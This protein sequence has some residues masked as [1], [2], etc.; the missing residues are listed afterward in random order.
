MFKCLIDGG[1]SDWIS[2]IYCLVSCG[3]GIKNWKRF[4]NF[5]LLLFGGY[6]C[7]G[8]FLEKRKCKF[9]FCLIDGFFDEWEEWLFCLY[10]C[11]GGI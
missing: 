3:G 6:N 7:S 9:Y 8:N 1:F 11:G 4:C 2:W 5:L 10:S